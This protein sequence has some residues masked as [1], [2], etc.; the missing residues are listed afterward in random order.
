MIAAGQSLLKRDVRVT[1]VCPSI[2]DVILRRRER[3]KARVSP[4]AVS[5]TDVA[6]PS[7]RSITLHFTINGSCDARGDVP[8]LPRTHDERSFL[9]ANSQDCVIVLV[10]RC[11]RSHIQS[12]HP[13]TLR[14]FDKMIHS[15][16]A[17][18]KDEIVGKRLDSNAVAKI[19]EHILR[20]LGA[21]VMM[22]WN[23]IPTKLQRE[24][25]D[26]AGSLT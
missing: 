17:L 11:D 6:G 20:C 24:L 22:Q 19:E 4:F 3:R 10:I 13:I 12:Q 23:T 1:S 5:S 26:T 21:A 25:F 9:L 15:Q 16:D 2:S 18:S 7:C 8:R 14:H